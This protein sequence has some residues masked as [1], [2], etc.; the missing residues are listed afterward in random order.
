[1]ILRLAGAAALVGAV[2]LAR[3]ARA[4]SCHG[5]AGGGGG[6]GGGGAPSGEL[7]DTSSCREVSDVVGH[8][9]CGRFGQ[10]WSG[11][12]T[13]P[14]LTAE[15]GL[16]ARRL[17]AGV[18]ASGVMDHDNGSFGY[19]VAPGG[20]DRTASGVSLRLAMAL[21]AHL[22]AGAEVEMGGL[23]SGGAPD[24]AMTTVD[25]TGTPSMLARDKAIMGA[26][27]VAGVRGRVG[28]VALAAEVV[29][30]ARDLSISVQSR[31]GACIRSR[32]HHRA[33]AFAEPRV[34]LD[35]W[36]TPWLTVAGTAG[37]E[38]DGES[39]MLGAELSFHLRAFDGGR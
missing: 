18:A 27:A 10:G 34:R 1:M 26:A 28:R 3:P 22:Y 37:S 38:L 8:E 6:E 15:L 21:P 4:D 12:A 16:F 17:D 14:P 29:A 20:G 24:V 23:V 7:V 33:A 30:G 5:P 19:E 11:R 9:R 13:L 36:L 35:F 2:A 32:T 31:D 25:G 39:R